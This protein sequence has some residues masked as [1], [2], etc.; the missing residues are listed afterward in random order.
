[1][2]GILVILGI[3][4]FVLQPSLVIVALMFFVVCFPILLTSF[5]MSSKQDTSSEI[6]NITCININ[7]TQILVNGAP[8]VVG[9]A[10]IVVGGTPKVKDNSTSSLVTEPRLVPIPQSKDDI[11][12]QFFAPTPIAFVNQN[13]GQQNQADVAPFNSNKKG[14][15]D[16]HP[17]ETGG[18]AS[19]GESLWEGN[20]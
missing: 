10:P 9:G 3:I 20:K 15:W 16:S 19:K 12:P 17:V 8:I 18:V 6:K 7:G 4:L 1:M 14:G 13:N 11:F 2:A 5:F